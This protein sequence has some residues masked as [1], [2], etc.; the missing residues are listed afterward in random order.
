VLLHQADS[1]FAHLGGILRGGLLAH[2][3]SIFSRK[4]ASSKPGAIHPFKNL[5]SHITK[6]DTIIYRASAR[7]CATCPMKEQCC[8]NMTSR[9]IHRSV[10]EKARDVARN[11]ATTPDY[12]RSRYERRKVEMLFAHLKSVL[13]LGR[14]RLH[15][16][17]GARNE[18]TLAATVQNL[19]RMAKLIAQGPPCDRKVAPA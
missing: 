3:G 19:R 9:K 13:N 8:P 4:G 12:Q 14:L 10:H 15:G 16:L 1:A 18:F 6:A 17:S 7:D 5:R 11:I 2:H